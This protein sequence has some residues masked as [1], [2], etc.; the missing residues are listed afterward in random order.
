MIRIEGTFKHKGVTFEVIQRGKKSVMLKATAPFYDCKSVEVWQLRYA[1][2][3]IIKGN[4]IDEREIK[5]SNEDYPYR[6]HQFMEKHF[7]GGF[8]DMMKTADK[9]FDEYETGIRPME[10]NFNNNL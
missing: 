7:K 9:R 5:P 8:V 10:T 3:S 4:K 6:A 2:A 1:K